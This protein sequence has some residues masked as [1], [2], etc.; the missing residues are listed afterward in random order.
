MK[1]ESPINE[2]V[3]TTLENDDEMTNTNANNDNDEGMETEETP[4]TEEFS[5]SETKTKTIPIIKTDSPMSGFKKTT[6]EDN[7]EMVE[8]NTIA[9]KE[10]DMDEIPA[11]EYEFDGNE[12]NSTET[13]VNHDDNNDAML[14]TEEN[15]DE[16]SGN[17]TETNDDSEESNAELSSVSVLNTELI[18]NEQNTT[19]AIGTIIAD[20]STSC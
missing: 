17:S 16:N 3:N 4:E 15:S 18:T 14:E 20:N 13:E 6:I 12:G 1:T 2:F 19:E 7:D 5:E 8:N 10:S 9:E 11:H